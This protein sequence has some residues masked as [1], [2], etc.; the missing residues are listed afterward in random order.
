MNPLKA[1]GHRIC[2]LL[3]FIDWDPSL[4]QK[5]QLQ[6]FAWRDSTVHLSCGCGVGIKSLWGGK[7]ICFF[8]LKLLRRGFFN[9]FKANTLVI[10]IIYIYCAVSSMLCHL[11]SQIHASPCLYSHLARPARVGSYPKKAGF[12]SLLSNAFHSQLFPWGGLHNMMWQNV[13]LKEKPFPYGPV[14]IPCKEQLN[15]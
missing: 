10:W 14:D 3:S 6:S 5:L 9:H 11:F 12:I 8:I 1:W 4:G 13:V 7:C 15:I 2:L